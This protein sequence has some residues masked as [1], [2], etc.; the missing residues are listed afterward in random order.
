MSSVLSRWAAAAASAVGLL[1]MSGCT[2]T[3][4]LVGAAGVATDSSMAWDIVKHVHAKL[5]DGAP[6]PC[7]QLDS[8]ER[9]ISPRCAPFVDGSVRAAD[10]ATSPH[11]ACALATAARDARLWPA[12]PELVAKGAR[13]QNCELPAA[14]AFAQ[15]HDCP[16]LGALAPPVRDAIVGLARTD[17]RAVHHDVVRWLSCPA[18][19]ANGADAVLDGWLADASLLPGTI[20]FNPLAA[21]HPGALATPLASALEAQGHRADDSLG[22]IL[23]LRPSGFEEA[24]RT[25]DWTALD[26]WLARAPQL[27]NRVPGAQLDWLPLARVMTPTF[28]VYPDSRAQLVDYLIAHGADPRT[29]LPSDPGQSVLSQ[30]RAANSPLLGLLEAAPA[31]SAAANPIVASNGRALRLITSTP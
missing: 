22:S 18:S 31:T 21:L 29:R 30:A 11:A 25:S 23:G 19:R 10:L 4:L 2:T 12:L 13:P 1:A 17:A 5:T 20:A 14:I 3:S 9:A 26:W 24:L 6:P 7:G 27:A 8:V 28:L 16:D 15:S